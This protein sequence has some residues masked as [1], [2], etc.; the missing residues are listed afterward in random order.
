MSRTLSWIALILVCL[1]VAAG[2]GFFKYGQ[3]QAAIAY[4]ASFPEPAEAVEFVIVGE[5]EVQPSSSVTGQVVAVR[6]VELLTEVAGVIARVGF[7]SAARVEAGQLLLAFDA[8]EEQA[9]VAAAEAALR[10]A[11]LD[12]E[13]AR[14]LR[15]TGAAALDVLDRAQA[16]WQSSAAEVARTKARLAKRQVL[17]PF[18]G[19]AGLHE[20]EP[21]QYLAQGTAVTR[22]VG[23]EDVLWID[24][25]VP[26]QQAPLVGDGV[27]V[28]APDTQQWVPGRV[29]ARDAAV[30]QR[31]RNL[32]FRAEVE[33]AA[34]AMMPGALVRVTVPLGTAAPAAVVPVTAVRRDAFGAR[35]FALVPAEEGAGGDER[36]VLRNVEIGEQLG[37]E[38][39]V[40]SGL[41]PGDRIAATGAF[42]LRDGVLVNAVPY[43][44]GDGAP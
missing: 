22:L 15:A 13:R 27:Q 18:A 10:L 19:T 44:A 30:D 34:L 12:R 21:G 39:V 42:K 31:S 37:T 35:V 43:L 9:E 1:L 24:F 28:S 7:E 26:Q 38:V 4:G 2:L 32:R 16:A 40:L 8:R 3:I 6:A 23:D 41:A 17:A 20:F 5:R 25:S 33:R 29:V 11:D 14:K 36:A